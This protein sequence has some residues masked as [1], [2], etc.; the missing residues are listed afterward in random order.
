MDIFVP[1]W[2]NRLLE[3]CWVGYLIIICRI[4]RCIELCCWGAFL[5]SWYIFHQCLAS[6]LYSTFREARRVISCSLRSTFNMMSEWFKRQDS[7][8]LASMDF[9]RA[10]MLLQK[11]V[12]DTSD[13]FCS[14]PVWFCGISCLL[15]E[16]I[17]TPWSLIVGSCPHTICCRGVPWS[18]GVHRW[19]GWL[20]DSS[21]RIFYVVLVGVARYSLVFLVTWPFPG[22]LW[23]AN[24]VSCCYV[25]EARYL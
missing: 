9:F 3:G 21:P 23:Y 24:P 15:M 16:N 7:W 5:V 8:V 14:R 22:H 20:Y 13:I 18:S 1:S 6:F 25:W 4:Y 11:T 12:I 19:S 2:R 10:L 17:S